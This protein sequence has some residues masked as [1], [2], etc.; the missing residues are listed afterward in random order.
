MA[1]FR[2][3]FYLYILA[4]VF[5]NGLQAQCDQFPADCP[6]NRQLP[7]SA[8]R[9]SNPLIPAEV[10]ME[11]RLHETLTGMMQ[12]LAE[13]KQWEL[14]QFDESDGSGYLNAA[15]TGPLEPGLRPPHDYEIAFVFIVNKDSLQAWR[16]WDNAWISKVQQEAEKIK[17]SGSGFEGIKKMQAEKKAADDRYRNASMIRVKIDINPESAIASSITENI[18]QT[19]SPHVP[20]ALVSQQWHNNVTDEHVIFDL[21]QFKRCTDLVFILMGE[22]NPNPDQYQRYHPQ[23]AAN[24]KTAEHARSNSIPSDRVR[25]IAMHVEGSPNYMQQFLQSLNVDGLNNLIVRK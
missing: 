12:E 16:E 21:D 22:W 10:S 18:H 5:S 4:S 7:D 24:G 15:R 20:H 25:A 14:Y 19:G 11:I 9:F 17:A 1:R 6:S 3:S 13:K 8:D 2:I 23:Y